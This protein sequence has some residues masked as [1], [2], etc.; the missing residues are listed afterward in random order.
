[1]PYRPAWR[2][3]DSIAYEMS[4]SRPRPDRSDR[5]PAAIPAHIA[6]CATSI[7]RSIFGSIC[8][9]PTVIAAS[10]CQPSTMAPQSREITSPSRRI[11]CGA[12]IACT[13]CSFTLEQI[14]AG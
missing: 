1:M 3:V 9:T 14:E 4:V 5:A 7:I 11:C 2:I 10:P 8:P 13:I 12:G 6:S